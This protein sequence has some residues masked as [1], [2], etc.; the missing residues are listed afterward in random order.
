[1]N[2]RPQALLLHALAACTLSG[3]CMLARADAPAAAAP[4]ASAAAPA[5]AKAPS[6]SALPMEA[7]FTPYGVTQ[8]VISPDGHHVALLEHALLTNQVKVLDLRDMSQKV[9]VKGQW[10]TEGFYRV[11]KTP[12]RISW[13]NSTWLAVDLGPEA[14]AV[15]LDGK[16]V[17]A[18][19]TKVIGK[20]VPADPE[21][22]LMLVFDDDDRETVALVDVKARKSRRLRHPMRGTALDWTFDEKGDLRTVMLADSSFWRDDTTLRLWYLP[23]GRQDWVEIDTFKITDDSWTPLAASAERDELVILSRQGRDRRAVFRHNPLAGPPLGHATPMLADDRADVAP[24][25]TLRGET[26]L[27]FYSLGLKP[28]RHW[29]DA[30]W[31]TV[32]AAVDE[33]L[34]GR[35]NELSGSTAGQVLIHSYSDTDPGRWHLLDV[36]KAELRLLA[37]N[38]QP[39]DRSTM[40]PMETYH[41]AAPDGLQIP[42]FLTRPADTKGPQPTVVLVHGG[43]ATRDYWGWNDEVQLLASRGYVVFQPQFR[44]STG[45]GKAF[46]QAGYGQWGLL[47]QDDITAGV[48]DLIRRGIADPARICIYGASYGG[49]AA[50]WGLVKTPELYRCGVTLAG[51]SD[52]GEMFTDWSDSNENKMTR[53]LMRLTIGDRKRDQATFDA[54]SPLRHASRIRAPVLIAHGDYDK[55]VPLGHARKLRAALEKAGKPYEWLVLDGEGHGMG[56]LHSQH[57]FYGRLL[58]FLARHLQ[59]AHGGP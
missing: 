18:L 44:G 42:A 32:Q 39:L 40:R 26:A 16:K 7:Y 5:A 34:P 38:R 27:S 25:E 29:L 20:A 35:I 51:V 30:N 15:D 41:Y 31:K 22:A 21:S 4:A 48:Q 55:R 9:I 49:Y 13:V 2:R 24:G 3:V 56:Y 52:I 58:E 46:E 36:P 17:A 37:L 43:P 11:L 50:M 1:M 47:M 28:T 53:E 45:F 54:V 10:V 57:R 19:G 8:A 33:V 23:H 12:R 59:A 14:Q 6:K